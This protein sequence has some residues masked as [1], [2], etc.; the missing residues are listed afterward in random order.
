MVREEE[1]LA[2]DER[3][4]EEVKTIKLVW[5]VEDNGRV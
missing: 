2:S 1:R 4:R 5:I 3:Q